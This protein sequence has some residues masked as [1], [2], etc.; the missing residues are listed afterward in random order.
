ME[1]EWLLV[2]IWASA[3]ED[4]RELCYLLLQAVV[5]HSP[6]TCLRR[7]RRKVSR[8]PSHWRG[9]AQNPPS[10]MTRQ[11]INSDRNAKQRRTHC[12]S[13]KVE[14]VRAEKT[15]WQR[16]EGKAISLASVGTIDASQMKFKPE[17]MGV[18]HGHD[19]SPTRVTTA[20]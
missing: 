16:M 14:V 10:M 3:G 5:V 8:R 15:L 19:A 17:H 13:P 20:D 9:G 11:S 6:V 4:R 18:A 7:T 1:M 2:G 12:A